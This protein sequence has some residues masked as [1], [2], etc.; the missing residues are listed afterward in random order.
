MVDA[1]ELMQRGQKAPAGGAGARRQRVEQAQLHVWLRCELAQQRVLAGG[2]EVV[3]QQ[4]HAHAPGS[5]IAQL[6]QKAQTDVVAVQLVVLRVDRAHRT[7]GQSD[8][9]VERIVAGGQHAKAREF[10]LRDRCRRGD[11]LRQR[12]VGHVGVSRRRVA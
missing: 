8:A 2:V 11:D 10:A 12:R 6:A 4:A 1:A 9:G 5:G 3:Q 7:A